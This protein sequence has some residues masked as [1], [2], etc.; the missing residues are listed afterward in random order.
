LDAITT[1]RKLGMEDNVIFISYDKTATY[2]FGAAKNIHAGRDTYSTGAI[3]TLPSF[4]HEY[5]LL[6][7]SIISSDTPQQVAEMGK[8][9][10]VYVVNAR[11]D[12]EKLYNQG[13]TFIMTDNV[14]TM[15]EYADKLVLD[16][17]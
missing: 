1:V 12:L 9:L 11:D 8:K 17:K 5:Y 14:V 7:K 16:Q 3:T 4:T 6:D 13:I 10:V 2:L 15:K